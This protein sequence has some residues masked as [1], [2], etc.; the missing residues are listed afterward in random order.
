M[1]IFVQDCC[2]G[3]ETGLEVETQSTVGY[4]KAIIQSKTGLHPARQC[5]ILYGKRLDDDFRTLAD[6]NIR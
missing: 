5:L 4:V 1:L 3:G 6:Y 2:G